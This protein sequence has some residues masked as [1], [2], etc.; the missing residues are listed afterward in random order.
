MPIPDMFIA[1]GVFG[2]TLNLNVQENPIKY[3]IIIS[4]ISGIGN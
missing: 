4:K 2:E 3:G 1:F